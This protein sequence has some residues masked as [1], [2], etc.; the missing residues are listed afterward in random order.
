VKRSV[1][2]AQTAL[3]D[4]DHAVAYIAKQNVAAARRVAAVLRKT[5]NELGLHATGRPGRASGTY[6][7]TVVGLPYIVAYEI[8]ILPHGDERIV[9]VHVI[10]TARDWKKGGWPK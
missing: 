7:R 4:Y 10:H 8:G 3:D 9:I 1:F 5:G 2:W 6:E